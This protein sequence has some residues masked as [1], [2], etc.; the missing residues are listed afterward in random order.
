VRRAWLRVAGLAVVAVAPAVLEVNRMLWTE[1]LF[2]VA[3]LGFLLALDR[4]LTR[5]DWRWLVVAVALVWTAF[6][7]RYIG[8][9]LAPAGALTL[10][11][12]PPTT[13]VRRRV[14]DAAVFGVA[15]VVVPF[16]WILRNE[17]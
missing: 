17:A 1:P 15:S 7:T 4:A 12:L 16:I 2:I 13:K 11:V 8:I 10:L 3:S 6:M 14:A 9:V 5:D